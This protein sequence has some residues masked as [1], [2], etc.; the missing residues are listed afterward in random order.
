MRG[1]ANFLMVRRIDPQ[2]ARYRL[3]VGRSRIHRYGVFALEEIPARKQV[4]EYTGK[5]L[6]AAQA[7]K[8]RAP[9]DRYIATVSDRWFADPS[10]GGSG[11]EFINHSCKPNLEWRRIRGHLFYFS[12]R[13]I[14]AGEELTGDYR[15]PIKLQ[16]VACR[17][18]ARACRGTLRY[19]LT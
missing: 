4:I 12:R 17:C 10:T 8:V 15:Y 18:G 14:R 2:Y 6:T 3:R 16:R 5:R 19:I 1:F 9:K 11:A 13:K 7:D